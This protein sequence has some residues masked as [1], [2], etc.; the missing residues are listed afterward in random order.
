MSAYRG[1]SGRDADIGFRP[2]LTQSWHLL[3]GAYNWAACNAI[4]RLQSYPPN[5]CAKAQAATLG[6]MAGNVTF[7]VLVLCRFETVRMVT[8]L[9]ERKDA[10]Q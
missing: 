5:T 6:R 3:Q 10:K 8:G 9:K 4:C 2:H 1:E 7:A